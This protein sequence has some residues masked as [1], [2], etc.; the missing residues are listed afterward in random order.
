MKNKVIKKNTYLSGKYKKVMGML[1]TALWSRKHILVHW[2]PEETTT[3]ANTV[4]TSLWDPE[5]S[6]C[7]DSWS[8]ETEIVNVCCFKAHNLLFKPLTFLH[9]DRQLLY[10]E[11][12]LD[13][14]LDLLFFKY[15]Q[16]V[17]YEHSFFFFFN[18]FKLS[19]FI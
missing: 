4:I 14:S 17:Q 19:H 9:S 5:Q 10:V 8:R 12:N 7:L 13:L 3:P 18:Y 2:G 16:K 11:S 1:P 6:P 15:W